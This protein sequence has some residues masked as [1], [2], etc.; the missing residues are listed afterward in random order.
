MSS[1]SVVTVFEDSRGLIW[2]ATQDGLNRFDGK[3]FKVYKHDSLNP[4]SINGDFVTNI[5]EDKEGMLW[6][7]CF[8]KGLCRFDPVKEKF[9]QYRHDSLN[10]NSL[11]NGY[12]N[13]AMQDSKGR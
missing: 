3:H 11:A 4:S 12:V 5:M 9:K 13:V 7:S 2:I 1:N 8:D 6:F 10:K